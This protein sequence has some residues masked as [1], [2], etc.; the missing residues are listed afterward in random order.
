MSYLKN[1]DLESFEELDDAELATVIGGSGTVGDV[2]DTVTNTNSA[3][4]NGAQP[5]SGAV[6]LLGGILVDTGNYLIKVGNGAEG[7]LQALNG[8]LGNVGGGL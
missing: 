6:I 8:G 3:L 2:V 1:A 7:G 4:G 5:T